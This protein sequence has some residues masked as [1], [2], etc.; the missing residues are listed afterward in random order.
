MATWNLRSWY[1]IWPAALAAVL[2]WGWPAWRMI[3][4]TAGGL[5]GYAVF[6][7]PVESTAE[8]YR[9]QIVSVPLMT[10]PTL[11]V[12]LVEVATWWARRRSTSAAAGL[13]EQVR[14]V[15]TAKR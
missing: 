11:V 7:W 8:F 1:L 12:T 10:G 15:V 6:F 2:P 13:P 14:E 9:V 5:A 4:W 3:A